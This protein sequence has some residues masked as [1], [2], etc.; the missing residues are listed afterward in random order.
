MTEPARHQSGGQCRRTRGATRPSI[1]ARRG[2]KI[3]RGIPRAAALLFFCTQ[4]AGA[5]FLPTDLEEYCR[6]YARAVPE[7]LLHRPADRYVVGSASVTRVRSP[8]GRWLSNL[9]QPANSRFHAGYRCDFS[10]THQDALHPAS[11]QLLVANTLGYA[12]HT[13]WPHLQ[14]I[15]IRAID[16]PDNGRTGYVVVKYLE[17][18]EWRK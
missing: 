17:G 14:I 7:R 6:S 13:Q 18:L 3:R 2:G 4:I 16:D 11:V 8:I 12:E 5:D 1:C 9:F 15:P 10:I